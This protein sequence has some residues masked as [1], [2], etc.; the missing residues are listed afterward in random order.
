MA[1]ARVIRQRRP[2]VF[3]ERKDI[4]EMYDDAE[5]VKRYCNGLNKRHK[6]G[7]H[8]K[9]YAM[10]VNIYYPKTETSLHITR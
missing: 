4:F 8:E 9:P 10:L 2:R 3:R 1:K 5:L 6:V 7:R